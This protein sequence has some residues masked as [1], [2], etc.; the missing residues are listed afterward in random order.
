MTFNIENPGRGLQQ[1]PS[2]DVL[3]KMSQE[4]EGWDNRT[5][6]DILKTWS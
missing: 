1:P 6:A 2:E 5:L 3:Q 4:D